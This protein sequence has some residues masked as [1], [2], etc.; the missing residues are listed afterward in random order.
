MQLNHA[1]M[2]CSKY[3]Q[4]CNNGKPK[5]A[6]ELAKMR[7]KPDKAK[8]NGKSPITNPIESYCGNS[9]SLACL[10]NATQDIA[11]GIDLVGLG[12]IETPA[13]AV[14]C[15]E[16]GPLGCAVA[17]VGVIAIWNTTLNNAEFAASSASL[18]FTILDDVNNNGGWGE[19]S[20]TSLTTW[21]AGLA[22]LTPSWDL[23]VDTYA[24]GYNHGL[25][26]GV[27]TIWDNGLF[28]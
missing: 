14:G 19:N 23:A 28:K 24:S 7:N 1:S 4:Y 27:N 11:T 2:S 5:S 13:V 3:P 12:L 21:V 15:V 18:V 26:N 25:F 16:G 6:D 9:S 20:S 8:E 10:A 17:E 22:P